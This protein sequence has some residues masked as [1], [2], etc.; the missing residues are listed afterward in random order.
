M[1]Q[2]LRGIFYEQSLERTLN[3]V[4][5]LRKMYYVVQKWA[6][7]SYM[8]ISWREDDKKNPSITESNINPAYVLYNK[9][10][11]FC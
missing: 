9:K 2:L 11:N 3:L 8:I 1:V 7:I 10:G 6:S 5:L 4:H